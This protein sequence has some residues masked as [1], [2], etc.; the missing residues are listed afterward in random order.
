MDAKDIYRIWCEKVEDFELKLEL[1]GI[2]SNNNEII[3]RFGSV[4]SFGTAGVRGIVGAGTN[5]MN[6]VTV[7]SISQA[8]SIYLRK[9]FK[10]PSVVISYDTRKFSYEFAKI[11]AEIFALNNIN[12]YF[13]ENPSPIGIL[14]LA[15]RNLSCSGGVM[16]TASHNP[17]EYNG[18][19][20]YN[21]LGAQP[22]DTER[23]SSI[24]NELDF[25]GINNKKK[26]SF[27]EYLANKKI[28]FVNKNIKSEYIKKIKS[29]VNFGNI[30]NIDIT[31]SPLNGCALDLVNNLFKNMQ[32]IHVVTEQ[33]SPD[34]LFKTCSPPDPQKLNSFNLAIKL[35]QKY[36]SDIIILNDPDGDR[37]GIA[38]KY[39]NKYK[40]LSGIEISALLI[41]YI[42]QKNNISGKILIKSIVT[43]G[44]SNI[45][46]DFY[47]AKC[48]NTLPGFKYIANYMHELE[49]INKLNLFLIGFEESNGFLLDYDIRDKDGVMTAAYFCDMIAYYKNLDINCIDILNNLYKKFGFYM[50]KNICFT[51]N[52]I[53]KI[54]KIISEFKNYFNSNNKNIIY[55][56]DYLISEE[57]NFINNKISKIN[58]PSCNMLGVE[59]KNNN[60]LF[61]RAS[62]TEPLVK[63]Y[64]LYNGKTKKTAEENCQKIESLIYQVYEKFSNEN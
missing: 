49:N 51:E 27:E 36:N 25:F 13:F 63:F 21:S 34:F 28:K 29:K 57:I 42:A 19:K 14:S 44:L 1:L 50:Q 6:S 45:I 23:I 3:S 54:K 48:I 2:S 64:I 59:F 17:P 37:L 33:K 20:I 7:S 52:N 16:I 9:K 60:K 62:G 5:R 31:Y 43:G 18:Y 47:G 39:K 24:F 12:V 61:I 40:I 11:S 53:G 4:L 58:L 55:L 30:N 56:S 22:I 26:L 15:L 10:F 8:F 32:N 46:A 35:A 38:L 41:N